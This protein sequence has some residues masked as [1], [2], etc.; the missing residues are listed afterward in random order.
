MLTRSGVEALALLRQGEHFDAALIDVRMPEMDG[1]TLARTLYQ[2]PATRALPI[3][4]ASGIGRQ[5]LSILQKEIHLAAWLNK[6][7]KASS[8]Y[9]ALVGVLAQQSLP[10]APLLPL[11]SEQAPTS[12]PPQSTLSLLL[13]EDNVINQK[14]AVRQLEKL[15]YR[16]DVVANGLELLE[17]LRRQPY[18]IVLTDIQMP[19]MDGFEA[20]R[21]ICQEWEPERRP[22]LIAMT[23]NAMKED[24]D[25]CLA[26]GLDDYVSKPVRMPELQAALERGAQHKA[27][28]L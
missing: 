23:A 7:I 16:P 14:V 13:A 22:Y 24:R 17:S 25:E 2:T 10:T 21:I 12:S 19:E 1:L 27:Q 11:L 18:D 6:P 3:I 5:N 15:G 4:I 9:N 26:A 20:A 28:Q 8:L